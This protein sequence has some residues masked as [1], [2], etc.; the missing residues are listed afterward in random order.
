MSAYPQSPPPERK[1][2]R[3]KITTLICKCLI[4][5]L[6]KDEAIGVGHPRISWDKYMWCW[7]FW[8]DECY[9][10]LDE[11]RRVLHP[12][13]TKD[14]VYH[15]YF[16]H[17]FPKNPIMVLGGM[18]GGSWQKAVDN[19]EEER[20]WFITAQ[21]C[22]DHI[23]RLVN[24]SFFMEMVFQSPSPV[25][26][27]GNAPTQKPISG[28]FLGIDYNGVTHGVQPWKRGNGENR[29][30]R[31]NGIISQSEISWYYAWSNLGG[32]WQPWRPY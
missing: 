19:V 17:R 12:T 32:G 15:D 9:I 1:S 23:L 22:I 28:I 18:Y 24:L 29:Q 26:M 6:P 30:W 7:V 10:W 16:R 13:H 11:S 27:G 21:A 5:S 4:S 14:E 25:F 2:E 8:K 31:K 20:L 3:I